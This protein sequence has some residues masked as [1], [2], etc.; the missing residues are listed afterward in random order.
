MCGDVVALPQVRCESAHE[1]VSTWHDDIK[2][3]LLWWSDDERLT[4]RLRDA[5]A[6]DHLET[7]VRRVS[8][9]LNG[10]SGAM[11]VRL[12]RPFRTVPERDRERLAAALN[13]A[14]EEDFRP[15][16]VSRDLVGRLEVLVQEVRAHAEEDRAGRSAHVY[17]KGIRIAASA[18]GQALAN[19]PRG[20][21]LPRTPV[22]ENEAVDS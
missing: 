5:S 2:N 9:T 1:A 16:D 12:L 15:E 7:R 22:Q 13:R 8:A 20:F 14:F 17:L 18:L 4:R 3:G 21:W 10:L 6:M 11:L 19:L